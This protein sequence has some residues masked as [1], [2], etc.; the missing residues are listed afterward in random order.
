MRTTASLLAS[1]I[2]STLPHLH[3]SPTPPV[4]RRDGN[5]RRTSTLTAA[6]RHSDTLPIA[7]RDFSAPLLFA[8]PSLRPPSTPP[9]IALRTAALAMASASAHA[10]QEFRYATTSTTPLSW[11]HVRRV[12]VPQLRHEA[13]DLPL[14]ANLISALSDCD[15]S[16]REIREHNDT[17]ILQLVQV[18]QACLQFSLWS[19]NILKEKV[20][21]L[22]SAQTVKGVSA[23]QLQSLEKR[24]REME[25]EMAATRKERDVLS[26]STANLRASL[27]QMETT[28]ELQEQQL[29]Q[30]RGRNARLVAKL[31][32]ALCAQAPL[33][34]APRSSLPRGSR[35][36]PAHRRH[37]RETAHRIKK[38]AAAFHC[39]ELPTYDAGARRDGS[40]SLAS[41]T[42]YGD[43]DV[44]AEVSARAHSHVPRPC[45]SLRPPPPS[46]L[47]WRTLVRYIIHEEHKVT[48]WAST[49]VSHLAAGT[50]ADEK[51]IT[52]ERESTPAKPRTS[53]PTA[54]L[55]AASAPQV[56]EEQLQAFFAELAAGVR[57]EVTA[58]SRAVAARAE[59]IVRA[60]AQQ[61]MQESAEAQ[62][63]MAEVQA[64]LG[65]LAAELSAHKQHV[66][67]KT[68]LPGMRSA[69]A[70]A[71]T[72]ANSGLQAQPASS[73]P[74]STSSTVKNS[75][76]A[77]APASSHSPSDGLVTATDCPPR[78]DSKTLSP[79]PQTSVSPLPPSFGSLSAGLCFDPLLT[80]SSP[81]RRSATGCHVLDS[82][83]KAQRPLPN[84][85][86][87]ILRTPPASEHGDSP[88]PSDTDSD[89]PRSVVSR[90]V[91]EDERDV[92]VDLLPL[93]NSSTASPPDSYQSSRDK[94]Y[95]AADVGQTSP[96]VLT[97]PSSAP[98]MC[99]NKAPTAAAD[100]VPPAVSSHPS[101][102]RALTSHLSMR[103]D[104]SEG[105]SY[106]SSQM[107]RETRA[108]LQALLEE[109]RASG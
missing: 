100:V 71:A 63:L 79:T 7:H 66:K 29:R 99:P 80:S 62:Q 5:A 49:I 32:K 85:S 17:D 52:G 41:D 91:E 96:R 14:M 102:H 56:S 9:P 75:S 61:R 39:T 44:S 10:L 108:Q 45:D 42:S 19:Q 109:E 107:L 35:L 89:R 103:S 58:Y 38:A 20:L 53:E 82:G 83:S 36:S 57:T 50:A 69:A 33:M 26:L 90:P 11:P 2:S 22:R 77:A 54:G 92:D 64:A 3:D 95:G 94:D 48:P 78:S 84:F 65:S 25:R 30:E 40:A 81:Q 46:F 87:D 68:P 1:R 97:K 28:V 76:P 37:V 27:L 88:A 72:S 105:S 6:R 8:S 16:L 4:P 34:S 73:S 51:R 59:E 55:K 106:G 23:P 67:G 101:P 47:D 24:Y 60:V 86:P 104:V 21:E 70:S 31:E 43:S 98:P 13:P 74:V 18:F 15:V 12:S 93:D